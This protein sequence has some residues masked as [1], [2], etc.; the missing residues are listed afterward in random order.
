[1]NHYHYGEKVLID[2]T[3]D[4]IPPAQ[5][6]WKLPSAKE[7]KL[8]G[9][10]L[11][12]EA[13]SFSDEGLY[14][15]MLDNGIGVANRTFTVIGQANRPPNISKPSIKQLNVTEGD[16]IEL[17]CHCEMCK[18]EK[19]QLG[20]KHKNNIDIEYNPNDQFISSNIIDSNIIDYSL[21]IKN[22]TA[23]NSG[24][25]NCT[26]SNS[27][28][29]DVYSIKINVNE[30]P[31]V[32]SETGSYLHK[33]HSNQ[34]VNFVVL[35]TDSSKLT[36]PSNVYDCNASDVNHAD[37]SLLLL[38]KF[39]SFKIPFFINTK[40]SR[41]ELIQKK[42]DQNS[43]RSFNVFFDGTLNHL[44]IAFIINLLTFSLFSLSRECITNAIA[45]VRPLHN[46]ILDVFISF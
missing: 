34:L 20:W 27:F 40:K 13:L 37:I 7:F 24:V 25:Y 9:N 3:A 42:K 29:S 28:G 1:M 12:I 45:Y 33:C 14:E 22:A 26:I 4:A 35:E 43:K 2:C 46:V 41:S 8:L 17:V 38:G 39:I 30:S 11:I 19:I 21:N 15:C 5:T 18:D 36:Y 16:D 31:K 23:D 6:K 44:I 32:A 10:P